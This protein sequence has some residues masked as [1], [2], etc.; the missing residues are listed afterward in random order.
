[1]AVKLKIVGFQKNN[2]KFKIHFSACKP[3]GNAKAS[4]MEFFAAQQDDILFILN[5]PKMVAVKQKTVENFEKMRLF[6]Q[7]ITFFVGNLLP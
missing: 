2:K 4:F 1:M 5:R 3:L 6:R 7:N